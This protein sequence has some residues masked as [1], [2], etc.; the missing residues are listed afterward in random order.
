MRNPIQAAFDWNRAKK[1]AAEIENHLAWFRLNRPTVTGV[2][3]DTRDPIAFRAIDYL[4]RP[5]MNGMYSIA[6]V[7]RMGDHHITIGYSDSYSSEVRSM[8]ALV[9]AGTKN[10][11][12]WRK[13]VERTRGIIGL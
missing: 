10:A 11:D 13:T 5:A 4:L 7:S 2:D 9:D 1:R 12:I 6:P 3:I 8:G